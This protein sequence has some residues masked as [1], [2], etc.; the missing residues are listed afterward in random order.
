[1]SAH[2][3]T[4]SLTAKQA[5]SAPS[6]AQQLRSDIE[7]EAA[8]T[9]KVLE[10]VPMERG[11]F[12]PHAKSMDLAQLASHVAENLGWFSAFLKDVM[13]FAAIGEYR[14]FAAKDRAELLAEHD[15]QL[16]ACVEG[17][18]GL[19]D[20]FLLRPWSMRMGDKVLMEE[21]RYAA[22][23]GTCLNHLVHHRGQLVVYLRLL[24]VPVPQVYGPTADFPSFG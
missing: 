20:A 22:I 6:L 15:K 19:D 14:P 16:A 13:D 2:P 11:S 8:K 23:R 1:M 7:H 21:P 24:D 17:L 12:K 4:A 10:V 9:R 3:T 5:S 18:A